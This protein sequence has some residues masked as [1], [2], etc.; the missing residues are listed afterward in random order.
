MRTCVN[1]NRIT[2]VVYP[3]LV[4]SIVPM[5]KHTE[6]YYSRPGLTQCQAQSA[7]LLL[8]E[9]PLYMLPPPPK[10]NISNS[11]TNKWLLLG[12]RK[13]AHQDRRYLEILKESWPWW[14]MNKGAKWHCWQETGCKPEE[15]CVGRTP[16]SP[17]DQD[18]TSRKSW[19][20]E[21]KL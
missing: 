12:I 4:H 3:C 13:L 14:R 9:T 16:E 6:M 7:N 15:T 21:Q 20:P 17:E 18:G 2:H 10:I 11:W 8:T 1:L 19:A 5:R